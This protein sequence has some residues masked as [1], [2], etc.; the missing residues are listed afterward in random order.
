MPNLGNILGGMMATGM[1]GRSRRGRHMAAAP[2][3]LPKTAGIAALGYL[4]YKAYKDYQGKQSPGEP[5]A[6]P[7]T[8][9]AGESLG[10]R[11]ADL[12][13]PEERAAP[14]QALGDQKALLLIRAMIAAAASDGEITPVERQRILDSLEQ[15]GADDEDRRFL[16][17]ELASPHPVDGLIR[18]VKDEETA[19]QVYLASTM[20]I[21][22]DTPAE[23]SYLRY[24]ADRLGIQ[25]G[26]TPGT[27]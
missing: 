18:N 3:G 11:L 1:A 17:N 19:Q 5:A 20:A 4:A 26:Q 16:A 12:L 25:P 9:A 22:A 23:Q 21:D 8:G 15:A 6:Q 13:R 24:L 2:L 14:E 27:A 10:D 7:Q